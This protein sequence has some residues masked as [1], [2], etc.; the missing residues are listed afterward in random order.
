MESTGIL[1]KID[2]L[3]RIVIPKEIRKKLK[4]HDDDYVEIFFS[5][6]AISLKKHSKVKYLSSFAQQLTDIVFSY[7]NNEIFIADKYNVIAYS[8]N[9]KKNYLNKEISNSLY[10]SINRRESIM[11][12]HLKTLKIDNNSEEIKCSFVMDAIISSSD[13]IGTIVM[14]SENKILNNSD[15]NIIKIINS[16]LNKYLED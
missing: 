6:D 8:G 7:T 3:G 15:M 10:E 2:E 4:I 12:N 5:D 13:S 14:Y 11:Q 9:N 1:R 16:F